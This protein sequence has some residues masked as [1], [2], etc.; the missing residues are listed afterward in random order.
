M[1][2]RGLTMVFQ[3]S[4]APLVFSSCYTSD[5]FGDLGQVT[6]PSSLDFII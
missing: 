4:Q 1:E 3:M 2:K 6:I 5:K